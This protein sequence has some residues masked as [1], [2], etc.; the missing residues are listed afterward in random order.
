V[1]ALERRYRW[2]LRAYPAWY[3][4][5]RAAEML[6]TLLEASPPARR[7]PSFREA[8][9]LVIGGLRVRGLL[10]S[11]LSMLWA[12]LGAAGAGYVFILST[13]RP[14]I[15]T[16]S[17]IPCWVGEPGVIIAAGEAGA[18]AWL[19]LTIPV[20]VA[21]LVRLRGSESWVWAW[22][23]AWVGGCALMF[24][25]ANWQPAAPAVSA[26]TTNQGCALAGYRHAVVSW[27]ELTVF[28]AWL[29]LGAALTLILA[30]TGRR[31]ARS[32][33][34]GTVPGT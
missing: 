24:P 20:L 22:A 7:W 6:G 32:V 3:R 33:P 16:Y 13:H 12:G 25:V 23:A 21:G 5:E 9:A 10:V 28:A 11:C 18:A 2:L 4:R 8:E 30:K 29:A 27:G 26:C 15:P 14:A 31:R 19:L 1:S 17:R 34:D